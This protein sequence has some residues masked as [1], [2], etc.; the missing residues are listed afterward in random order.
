MRLNIIRLGS[1]ILF[2]ILFFLS[3]CTIQKRRYYPGYHV[4]FV[5]KNHCGE[6]ENKQHP[7]P[8]RAAGFMK[9]DTAAVVTNPVKEK[10][11]TPPK[12]ETRDTITERAIAPAD[13]VNVQQQAADSI[14]HTVSEK[15]KETSVNQQENKFSTRKWAIIIGLSILL[16]AL[17]AGVVVT[18][19]GGLFVLGNTA[20]T[21]AL[22]TAN[23]GRFI[24][25][26]AGWSTILMLDV[27]IGLGVIRYYKKDKPKISALA[28]AL[29]LLYS[30]VLAVGIG[31][32]I[33]AAFA[34]SAASIYSGIAA[35][36]MFWGLGL[37]LFGVHLIVLGI[38]FQNE[39]G[40]QWVTIAIKTLLIL[41]GIG[42]IV[43][44]VGILVV[45]NPL[46][47][48]ATMEAIFIVPMII[49]EI[50]YGLWKLFKGGKNK[51]AGRGN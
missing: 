30:A 42:Y 51:P 38:T 13:T 8:E 4:E 9:N 27:L 17:T 19:L 50:S 11:S 37:I 25:A 32:L 33:K 10:S 48:A 29:R 24:A 3:A 16:L 31:H 12:T 14:R 18:A 7:E 35:F 6:W 2:L 23:F 45:A 41:A 1:G 28:G 47:F 36:N 46:V 15:K 34:S 40:K 26:I 21:G 43:Q 22:V 39:G 44:Y 49:S 5:K 20:L